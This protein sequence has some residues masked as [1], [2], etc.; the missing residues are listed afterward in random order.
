[1]IVMDKVTVIA[2]VK[3]GGSKKVL[4]NRAASNAI[5]YLL[6]HDNLQIWQTRNKCLAIFLWSSAS[7][8]QIVLVIFYFTV[9]ALLL[10]FFCE[11]KI[12]MLVPLSIIF[13]VIYCCCNSHLEFIGQILC[14]YCPYQSYVFQFF[15]LSCNAVYWLI[16]Y[17]EIRTMESF[18]EFRGKK[19]VFLVVLQF[20][21][22]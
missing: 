22:T 8:S 19:N 7:Y 1:M 11:K 17:C 15:N 2:T 13:N 4:R 20:I 9:I 18:D 21:Y 16:R 12:F 14:C 10:L 6:I 5:E 3:Y